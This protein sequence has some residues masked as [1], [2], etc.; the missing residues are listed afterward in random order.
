LRRRSGGHRASPGGRR[1]E[2]I[3][4]EIDI[5]QVRRQRAIGLRGLGQVLKS[6]HDREVE[7]TI[8]DRESGQNGYLH[9]LGSLEMPA[10][11]ALTNG[12]R[13]RSMHGGRKQRKEEKGLIDGAKGP[14][15]AF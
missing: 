12:M 3:P 2:V 4:I 7:F 1:R 9:T 15:A 11:G 8:Y 6:F 10:R 5:E 14:T 13:K